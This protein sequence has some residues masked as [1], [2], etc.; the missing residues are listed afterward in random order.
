[1]SLRI[2]KFIWF[3]RLTKT[4]SVAAELIQKGKVKLNGKL[5][6]TSHEVKVNDVVQIIKNTA[7]FEYKVLNL[8][9][10]R[11]GAKLVSEYLLD[12][13]SPD[14]KEKFRIYQ[15]NQAVYRNYGTGKPSKHDRK[16]INGF[17]EGFLKSV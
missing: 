3:V 8:L 1:M 17:I 14:E 6:K 9:D 16:D 7:T 15:V 10:R 4:R 11:I 13:T 2:D 5:V 12:I